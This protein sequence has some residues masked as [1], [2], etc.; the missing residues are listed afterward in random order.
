MKSTP[1]IKPTIVGWLGVALHVVWLYCASLAMLPYR[2][3]RYATGAI[4]G[5]TANP[6]Y[7]GVQRLKWVSGVGGIV[8]LGIGLAVH[9]RGRGNA[10]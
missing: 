9:A 4:V 7:V 1:V 8:G 2:L 10:K 6:E 5:K 3:E